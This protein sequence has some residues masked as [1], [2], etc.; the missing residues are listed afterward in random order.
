MDRNSKA[1]RRWI[2]FHSA[3]QLAVSR[4]SHKWTSVRVAC[5]LAVA[6]VRSVLKNSR[7]AFP[8]LLNRTGIPRLSCLTARLITSRVRYRYVRQFPFVEVVGSDRWT[9]EDG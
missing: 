9:S 6:H 4:A 1:S 8:S 2:H 7:Y 5:R 3:L